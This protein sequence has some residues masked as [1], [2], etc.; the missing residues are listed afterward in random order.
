MLGASAVN[1]AAYLRVSSV[2]PAA[3]VDAQV[4]TFDPA[5]LL[6]ALQQREQPLARFRILS[7]SGH[8]H[9]K[10]PSAAQLLL[11]PRR[12]RPHRRRAAEQRDE[13]AAFHARF[14]PPTSAGCP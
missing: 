1:S 4:M 12:E 7:G 8:E 11:R 13:I 14:P 9:A 10:A 3:D 2:L 5:E 6:Q